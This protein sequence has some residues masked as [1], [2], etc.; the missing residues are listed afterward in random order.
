M[1]NRE[2]LNQAKQNVFDQVP[3]MPIF[4]RLRVFKLMAD[5]ALSVE[6]AVATACEMIRL[7]ETGKEMGES[8]ALHSRGPEGFPAGRVV[9]LHKIWDMLVLEYEVKDE[10]GVYRYTAHIDDR[11]WG[12]ARK[13]MHAA[14]ADAIGFKHDGNTSQAGEFFSRMLGIED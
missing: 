14:I 9:H 10:P 2:E 12:K 3:G 5:H 6:Q 11:H 4:V 8:R 13:D 7:Y 1:R